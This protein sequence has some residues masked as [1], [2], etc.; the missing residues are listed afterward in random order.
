MSLQSFSVVC[1]DIIN[2]QK[3]V[4]M[5][6]NIQFLDSN[7]QMINITKSVSINNILSAFINNCILFVKTQSGDL[8]IGCYP[9]SF[10]QQEVILQL[11]Q[12]SGYENQ[13]IE[14]IY[15]RLSPEEIQNLYPCTKAQKELKKHKS[16]YKKSNNKIFKESQVP[17]DES[18][19][20]SSTCCNFKKTKTESFTQNKYFQEDFL[21]NFEAEQDLHLQKRKISNISHSSQNISAQSSFSSTAIPQQINLTIQNNSEESNN[22]LSQQ[23]TS[24]LNHNLSRSKERT[25][26]SAIKIVSEWRDLYEKYKEERI[27]R[28]L[29]EI[30]E[31]IGLSKKVLDYYFLELRTAEFFGFDFDSNLEQKFGKIRKFNNS[32]K[33][34]FIQQNNN[35]K[36]PINGNFNYRMNNQA[37][38]K[39]SVSCIQKP[40]KITNINHNKID[41]SYN[42]QQN[43]IQND[44]CYQN[45]QYIYHSQQ[46]QQQQQFQQQYQVYNIPTIHL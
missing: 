29:Q 1:K 3:F 7:K 14:F 17:D 9:H 45:Q 43:Q 34:Q 40:F 16:E 15:Q 21:A 19:S 6:Q 12:I 26:A 23:Q 10:A 31:E 36:I 42:Q 38:S 25:I 24:I 18:I 44:Y 35:K 37:P 2:Q 33:Q 22:K 11:D 46:Q 28:D 20:G 13:S 30:A 8:N 39:Q 41:L 5:D 4:F 27:F 32:H